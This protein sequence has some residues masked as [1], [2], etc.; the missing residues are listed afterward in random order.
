ML[1]ESIDETLADLLGIRPR[2]QFYDHLS[3][4]YRYGREEIPRKICEFSDFLDDIFSSGGRAVRTMIIHRLCD[5]LGYDI[6]QEP[7]LEFYDYLDVLR[8]R[9]ARDADKREWASQT[10]YSQ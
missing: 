7:G 2:D 3:T 10:S 8:A 4:R 5:K 9:S 6:H 1:L